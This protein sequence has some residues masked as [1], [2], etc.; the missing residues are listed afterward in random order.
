MD[1]HFCLEHES[2]LHGFPCHPLVLHHTR[3]DI[4]FVLHIMTHHFKVRTMHHELHLFS[5]FEMIDV[6]VLHVHVLQ[7]HEPRHHG[8]VH[9]ETEGLSVKE[10][11]SKLGQIQDLEVRFLNR[12]NH[13][14]EL[15]GHSTNTTSWQVQ[16]HWVTRV[17]I[18]HCERLGTFKCFT[19]FGNYEV[20]CESVSAAVCAICAETG[21]GVGSCFHCKSQ[22]ISYLNNP[23]SRFA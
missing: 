2:L 10:K 5:V 1:Q 21:D 17:L 6:D 20:H 23:S 4:D 15:E 8:S 19:Q 22:V 7:V 11:L 13:E 14:E 3:L 18:R 9:W 12:R 16:V